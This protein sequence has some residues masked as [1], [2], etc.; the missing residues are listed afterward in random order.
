M[1]KLYAQIYHPFLTKAQLSAYFKEPTSNN[2]SALKS[3]VMRHIRLNDSAISALE[4]IYQKPSFDF[5]ILRGSY[6]AS[7]GI[8]DDYGKLLHNANSKLFR[9]HM[10]RDVNYS[11]PLS[12]NNFKKNEEILLGY[13]KQSSQL[14]HGVSNLKNFLVVDNPNQSE[15]FISM[16]AKLGVNVIVLTESNFASPSSTINHLF[17]RYQMYRSQRDLFKCHEI[18]SQLSNMKLISMKSM[19]ELMTFLD[20]LQDPYL[21]LYQLNALNAG[22]SMNS[23]DKRL[24]EMELSILGDI[25]TKSIRTR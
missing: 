12:S 18:H 13:L 23:F 3:F 5:G 16:A 9:N 11:S 19:K 7:L 2:L 4:F 10:H 8:V 20:I 1:N 25:E 17:Q 15:F 6:F 21:R 22:T 14:H 24:L